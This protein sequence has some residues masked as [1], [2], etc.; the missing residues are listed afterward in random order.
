MIVSL[1]SSLAAGAGLVS[2]V[3]AQTDPQLTGTWTTKS[4]SVI[5]GPGFYDP[6]NERIF[7]PALTGFSYSFT[8]DGHYEEAYY[9]AVSN[10][11]DPSCPQGIIQW[12]H[13]T[14]AK[15]ANGSLTLTPFG[16]DGRQ[17]L[18][19]PCNNNNAVFTR[20][21]QIELFKDY[22]VA[23]DGYSK[24]R[25]LNLFAFDGSPLNPMYLAY[26]PPE[27]LPT[28][29]LN[30]TATASS[31]GA[32]STAKIRRSLEDTDSFVEP[33]NKNVLR[34]RREPDTIASDRTMAWAGLGLL[35]S[36]KVEEVFGLK[37]TENDKE[38][39]KDVLPRVRRVD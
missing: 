26:N 31:T 37:P 21:N 23:V 20:Y 27:M 29:T 36:D 7:E 28:Q 15:N 4:R 39:P 11:A 18:S 17:L 5:T 35:L 33:Q 8:D 32:T 9:R 2:L 6:V 24:A 14:Y 25:R 30:P 1:R 38:G 34:K 16:V 12:Q 3:A 19:D 13:G 22:E 10:P